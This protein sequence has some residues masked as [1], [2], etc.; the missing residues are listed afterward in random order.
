MLTTSEHRSRLHEKDTSIDIY[1][2]C[3]MH[4]ND[5]CMPSVCKVVLFIQGVYKKKLFFIPFQMF[6][7]RGLGRLFWRNFVRQGYNLME[8]YG[9]GK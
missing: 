4:F 6:F 3:D 5:Y 9:K 2:K 7:A 8:R 1:I